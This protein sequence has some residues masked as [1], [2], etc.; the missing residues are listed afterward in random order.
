MSETLLHCCSTQLKGLTNVFCLN[1]C[2]DVLLYMCI[3]I[4]LWM[5]HE[6]TQNW[7]QVEF[8]RLIFLRLFHLTCSTGGPCLCC[9]VSSTSVPRLFFYTWEMWDQSA[10][11]PLALFPSPWS[12]SKQKRSL[13]PPDR[14]FPAALARLFCTLSWQL[15]AAWLLWLFHCI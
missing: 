9:T 1:Y 2:T 10:E 11:M 13:F 4:V 12:L 5:Y 15:F 6:L 7:G 14:F 3:C 8:Y